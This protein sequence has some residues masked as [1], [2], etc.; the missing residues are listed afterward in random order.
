MLEIKNYK[1]N[2]DVSEL[3]LDNDIKI[4]YNREMD[5]T[6]IYSKNYVNKVKRLQS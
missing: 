4:G 2:C 5:R 1:I 6:L 3:M